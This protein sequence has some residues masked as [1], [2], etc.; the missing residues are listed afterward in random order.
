M[1]GRIDEVEKVF[2]AVICMVNQ[3]D[4][5]RFDGNAPLTLDVHVVKDLV[6]HL[7]FCEHAGGLD[8]AV[9]ERGFAVINVC[10]DAEITDSFLK[11]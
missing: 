7:T 11:R 9:R 3:A 4:S 8:H 1:A 10:D 6:L 2:L 5:L